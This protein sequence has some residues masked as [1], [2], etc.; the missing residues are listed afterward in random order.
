MN[1]DYTPEMQAYNR[2]RLLKRT[3]RS[4]GY[5]LT[6]PFNFKAEDIDTAAIELSAIIE[7]ES[8]ITT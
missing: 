7:S 8:D 4:V 5:R 6:M 1:K 2:L 3:A